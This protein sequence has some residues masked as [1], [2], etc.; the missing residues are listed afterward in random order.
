MSNSHGDAVLLSKDDGGSLQETLYLQS[1]PS[2]A[3]S[4]KEAEMAEDW[5]SEAEFLRVLDGM[6]VISAWS[7]YE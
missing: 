5:V 1:I 7:H 3:E 4:I 2:L 6:E